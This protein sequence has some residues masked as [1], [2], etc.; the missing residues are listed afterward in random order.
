MN[1]KFAIDDY[2]KICGTM[3]VYNNDKILGNNFQ[4]L[5]QQLTHVRTHTHTDT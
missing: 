3:Q 5:Q 4:C 2:Y 1:C